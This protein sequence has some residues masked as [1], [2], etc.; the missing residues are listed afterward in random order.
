MFGKKSPPPQPQPA[1]QRPAAAPA[2][3]SGWA[4]QVL[5]A[6]CL[7]SGYIQPVDAPL[8]GHL[9]IPNQQVIILTQAQVR[10]LFSGVTENVPEAVIPKASILVLI[11]KDETAMRS[12][13][14]QMAPRAERAVIYTGS[15]VVHAAFRLVGDMAVRNIYGAAGGDLVAVT[16][17]DI[18]CPTLGDKFPPLQAPL[19][20]LNKA[21]VQTYY[22]G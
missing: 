10:H 5:T 17:I 16:D 3:P 6:D 2:R 20:V 19:A 21:R 11:P 22:P 15:Y 14:M 1:S 13:A 4:V 12:A 18:K 7:V 9:N 8:V